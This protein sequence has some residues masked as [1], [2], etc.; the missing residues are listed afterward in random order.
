MSYRTEESDLL[1]INLSRWQGQ[2]LSALLAHSIAEAA[3]EADLCA[4]IA[5]M[6]SLDEADAI[7]RWK[8]QNVDLEVRPDEAAALL[9][10]IELG[11]DCCTK[12]AAAA[13]DL[14][15]LP[16]RLSTTLAGRR[17]PAGPAPA[18]PVLPWSANGCAWDCPV[19]A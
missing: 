3:Q 16:A 9:R 18:A 8:R 14:A 10:A 6:E 7:A 1:V 19:G 13:A 17:A 12:C 15:A 5:A 2:Q 4:L 11:P